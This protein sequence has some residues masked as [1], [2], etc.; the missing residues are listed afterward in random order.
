MNCQ[1]GGIGS[2]FYNVFLKSV[3][4]NYKNEYLDGVRALQYYQKLSKNGSQERQAPQEEKTQIIPS[5]Q[6]QDKVDVSQVK[7]CSVF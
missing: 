2:L 3:Y 4:I 1:F 7:E 6:H 5:N